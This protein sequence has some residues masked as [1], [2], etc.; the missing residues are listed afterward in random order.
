MLIKIIIGVLLPHHYDSG[1][2]NQIN[3]S[4]ILIYSVF[5]EWGGPNIE[6]NNTV[7]NSIEVIKYK[8]FNNTDNFN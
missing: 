1:E 5:Y 8:Y 2:L 6:Y 4:I 3:D 7:L